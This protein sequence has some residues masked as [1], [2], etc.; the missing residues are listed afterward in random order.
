M[1]CRMKSVQPGDVVPVKNDENSYPLPAGLKDGD[2][3]KLIRFES[4]DW[5]VEKDGQRY[6]VFLIRL[7]T[8]FEYEVGGRWLPEDDPRVKEA[9]ARSYGR[10]GFQPRRHRVSRVAMAASSRWS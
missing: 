10:E 2:V 6:T 1:Q 9:Q 7:D 4:G 5:E 3:V 8:G